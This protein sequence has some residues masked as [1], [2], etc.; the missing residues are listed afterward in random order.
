MEKVFIF[1]HLKRN[2]IIRTQIEY[3]CSQKWFCLVGV[4]NNWVEVQMISFKGSQ[5]LKYRD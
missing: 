3:I 2:E 5:I 1:Y 4:K